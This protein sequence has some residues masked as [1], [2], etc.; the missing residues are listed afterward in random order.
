MCVLE[1][2][3]GFEVVKPVK[4]SPK[5]ITIWLLASDCSPVLPLPIRNQ[6][7]KHEETVLWPNGHQF[8]E[9]EILRFLAI[10]T[11]ENHI[12]NFS[13]PR[14]H[15]VP[16]FLKHE[17]NVLWPNGHQFWEVK[18]LW[19]LAIFCIANHI[20]HAF[21]GNQNGDHFWLFL[22]LISVIWL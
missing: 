1:P 5:I 10:F 12:F 14:E 20:S 16:L 11:I 19:F 3:F 2:N 22:Q 15:S 4:K 8:W 18:F 17:E 21:F 7:L 6:A 9:V 13:F